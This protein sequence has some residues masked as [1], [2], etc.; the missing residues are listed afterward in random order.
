MVDIMDIFT[1]PLILGLILIIIG[2]FGLTGGTL[3]AINMELS[4]KTVKGRTTYLFVS[5]IIVGLGIIIYDLWS[6]S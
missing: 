4:L 5:L 1:E 2:A 6:F 3:K